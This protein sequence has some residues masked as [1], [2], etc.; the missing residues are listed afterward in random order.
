MTRRPP[1]STRTDTILPYTTLVRS[2]DAR[3]RIGAPLRPKGRDAVAGLEAVNPIAD[4]DHLARRLH[5]DPA[6]QIDRIGAV[7]V[8]DVDI[9][10]PD[11]ALADERLAGPG[12]AE[13][14]F[15][16]VDYIGSA[17]LP[18]E[19]LDRFPSPP[20]L[21]PIHLVTRYA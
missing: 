17:L 8:I 14:H 1:R 9:V 21:S 4:R 2:G 16:P 18:D 7:A 11:R 10:E 19:G 12:I 13:G 5:A 15:A 20:P 3:A 6:G